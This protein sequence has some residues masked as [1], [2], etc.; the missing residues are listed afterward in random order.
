MYTKMKIEAE[1]LRHASGVTSSPKDNHGR[2]DH[3]S[4]MPPERTRAP[5]AFRTLPI[6]CAHSSSAGC[7]PHRR[8]LAVLPARVLAP[9]PSPC[10]PFPRLIWRYGILKP[11]PICRCIVTGGA[12]SRR[13][14]GVL[15]Y[16]CGHTCTT[17]CWKTTRHKEQGFKAIHA[18]CGVWMKTTYGMAKRKAGPMSPRQRPAAGRTIVVNGKYISPISRRAV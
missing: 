10:P 13:R 9:A 15:P 11:P 4:G 7:S 16:H 5:V 12:F 6:T 8:Y 17:M 14:H 1:V 3:R 18:Q 2:R